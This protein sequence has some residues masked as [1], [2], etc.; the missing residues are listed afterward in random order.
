MKL[1]IILAIFALNA[2]NA[3]SD[4]EITKSAESSADSAISS[5]IAF[6]EMFAI[7]PQNE[8]KDRLNDEGEGTLD[9]KNLLLKAK[10]NY[11]MQAKDLAI[12]QAKA[13][14]DAVIG[15]YLP[16]IDVGYNFGLAHSYPQNKWGKGLQTHQLQA[17]ASWVIFDGAA[18]EYSLLSNNALLRAA[19]ADKGYSEESMF[20]QTISLYYQYF[21]LKGQMIAMEQKKI[22]I[23][24]NVA[25]IEILYNAGLQPIDALESLKA[26]FSN[27][28]Y[29]LETIRLNL[30]QTKM[31]LSLLANDDVQ[32]LKLVAI[33]TPADKEIQSLNITMQEEQALSL[34]YQAG[35]ITYFPTISLFDTYSWNF[36]NNAESILG[37]GYFSQYPK[38]QNVFGISVSWNIFSGFT[39]NRQKEA[40]KLSS[41]MVSKNIA[42]MRDEQK[43][44]IK[45]YKKSIIAAQS[46]INSAKAALKSATTSFETILQKYQAQLVSYNDYLDSLIAKYNA[47][48]VYIQSLNNFELQKANYIFYSGQTLLDYID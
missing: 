38:Q 42:Y 19:I 15:R 48:S 12:E 27:T 8:I 34:D 7:N 17:S 26:E 14:R 36:K 24:A 3:A 18:R 29:Q 44:N 20:L 1:K 5:V 11:Q 16:S 22:N 21:S 6:E 41:L 9:L 39:T 32:K 13:T 25:R 23:A 28:E 31:Q 43:N 35:T 45:F 40:L 33:K 37:A 47:E 46:Q 2:L 10:Q 30:E 4:I